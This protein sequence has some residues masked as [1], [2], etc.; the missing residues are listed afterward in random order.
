MKTVR[1]LRDGDS[2]AAVQPQP[3]SPSFGQ[4]TICR[5]RAHYDVVRS[6][7]S[8]TLVRTAAVVISVLLLAS[9]VG[10]Y[11]Y[12]AGQLSAEL[13]FYFTAMRDDS[14]SANTLRWVSQPR[15]MSSVPGPA[16]G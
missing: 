6:V 11:I 12:K 8:S 16:P 2:Q 4:P 13:K 10:C 7:D 3:L 5:R 15:R 9:A 14:N 1:L